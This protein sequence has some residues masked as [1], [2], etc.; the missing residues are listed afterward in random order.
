MSPR[1]GLSTILYGDRELWPSPRAQMSSNQRSRPARGYRTLSSSPN[2]CPH[3]WSEPARRNYA[4]CES[5]EAPLL[6]ENVPVGGSRRERLSRGI[7]PPLCT[8]DSYVGR[9]VQ[10]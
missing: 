4:C 1:V 2:R 8:T 3:Q 5:I 10:Q 7:V 6:F 9:V